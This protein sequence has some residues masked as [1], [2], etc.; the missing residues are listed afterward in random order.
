M[1][2]EPMLVL[3]DKGRA[4]I[5]NTA[6]S[7]LLNVPQKDIHGMDLL[8]KQFKI[9]GQITMGSK[10]KT[11]LK[12]GHSFKTEAFE[13]HSAAGKQKFSLHARI[14]KKDEDFPYRILLEFVKHR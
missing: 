4:V 10:L 8:G 7:E 2:P 13:V 9:L 1:N 6:L 14:I 11:A 3:D 12:D 5:G